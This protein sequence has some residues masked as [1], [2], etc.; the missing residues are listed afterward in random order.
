MFC[1]I[2]KYDDVDKLKEPTSLQ[3]QVKERRLKDKLGKRNFHE[4]LKLV[5]ELVTDT[6]KQTAQGAIGA[7]K[8]TTKA[9]EL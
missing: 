2:E 6:V 3:N 5:L 1:T 9:L 4:N 8:D 7:V